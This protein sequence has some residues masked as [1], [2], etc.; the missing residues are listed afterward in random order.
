MITAFLWHLENERGNSVRTRNARL[1]A[2]HSFFT[3]R[4]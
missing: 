1:T 4:H 3:T 2:I